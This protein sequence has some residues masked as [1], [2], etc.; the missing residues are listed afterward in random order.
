MQITS[1]LFDLDG[2]LVDSVR[3]TAHILEDMCRDRGQPLCNLSELRPQV[4]YGAKGLIETALPGHTNDMPKLITEFRERYAT[5]PTPV[6]SLYP[7]T[8]TLLK[9][10]KGRHFKL[11]L[12]TNKPYNLCQNVIHQTGIAPYFD[13]VIA[14]DGT[15]PGKPNPAPIFAAAQAL[16]TQVD[17]C[18]L[19]GDSSVDQKAA[20]AAGMKFAFFCAGYDDGVRTNQAWATISQLSELAQL[21]ALQK[22]PLPPLEQTGS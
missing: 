15:R 18:L 16:N 17:N 4:S 8:I 14:Q 12:C 1:I 22:A 6:S 3:E 9:V 10:L 11:S 21:D 7:G 2:T 20:C 19:V 5:H 13:A